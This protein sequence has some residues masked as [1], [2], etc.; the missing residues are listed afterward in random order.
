MADQTPNELTD[1]Q[2]K[3]MMTLMTSGVQNS[4]SDYYDSDGE[5]I[6]KNRIKMSKTLRAAL[7]SKVEQKELKIIESEEKKFKNY[8]F[9]GGL[10]TTCQYYF[11]GIVDFLAFITFIGL[12]AA[13]VIDGRYKSAYVVIFYGLNF[14]ALLIV[15]VEDQLW[16]RS[17]YY[18]I[19]AMKT[20]FCAINLPIFVI[21]IN[22]DFLAKRFCFSH[23]DL[24]LNLKDV[25]N[26]T[27]SHD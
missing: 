14:I 16:S 17:V 10:S 4:D 8:G 15:W 25:H 19:T 3:K 7:I 13:R 2:V 1:R 6:D 11:F 27:L 23:Q 26:H 5:K 20:F 24:P 22:A 21:N 9:L 12:F 18:G